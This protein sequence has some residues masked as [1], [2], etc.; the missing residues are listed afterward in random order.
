MA[1]KTFKLPSNIDLKKVE[2]TM[3][4]VQE[5]YG[6]KTRKDGETPAWNHPFAVANMIA[7]I[8]GPEIQVDT[9]YIALL[10][11]VIEDTDLT[12]VDIKKS[13]GDHI[14]RAVQLLTKHDDETRKQ[15]LL[16]LRTLGQG[17]RA[18]KVLDRTHNLLDSM[19]II[20][21]H[22]E[23]VQHYVH[24]SREYILPLAEDVPFL[25][26]TL[27]DAIEQVEEVLAID[28]NE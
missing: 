4:M 5:A 17:F 13:H 8:Q 26:S 22:E 24:E 7:A 20:E 2:N 25:Y 15:Y 3:K 18:V 14:A 11:D 6:D 27:L 23:F 12:I 9:Y 19:D 28:L 16:R 10:H 21:E 1:K